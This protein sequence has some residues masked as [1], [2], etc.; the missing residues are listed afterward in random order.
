[1]RVERQKIEDA[2]RAAVMLEQAER[3]KVVRI[4][5]I[6]KKIKVEVAVQK[7]A[8]DILARLE[9]GLDRYIRQPSGNSEQALNLYT[10]NIRA[11]VQA[12][13]KASDEL[14]K[15]K[16][17][18]A[19]LEKE[20]A[21]I[22]SPP[23]VK[24]V[25]PVVVVEPTPVVVVVE[26]VPEPA[27][28]MVPSFLDDGFGDVVPTDLRD[29]VD[30]N[31]PPLPPKSPFEASTEVLPDGIA[32]LIED[33][34]GISPLR[35]EP[36]ESLLPTDAKDLLAEGV[37]MNAGLA[38]IDDGE[39]EALKQEAGLGDVME[40]NGGRRLASAGQLT[41]LLFGDANSL[42]L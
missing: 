27:A 20:L 12:K 9:R 40:G 19:K 38:D 36:F 13:A 2:K 23:M 7:Q 1:M 28:P 22:V 18:V 10:D 37:G 15:I 17:R 25:V 14:N 42:A 39:F 29:L 5:M 34:E 3:M 4:A 31:A 41:A 30:E 32:D 11:F 35:E 8:A 26:P 24:P 33:A 21:D 16:A 6:E